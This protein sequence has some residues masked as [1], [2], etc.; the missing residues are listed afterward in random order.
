MESEGVSNDIKKMTYQV[1]KVMIE[2]S[3]SR[4]E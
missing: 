3:G 1:V 4:F 2:K